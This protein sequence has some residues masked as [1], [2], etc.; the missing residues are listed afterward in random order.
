MGVGYNPKIVTDGL[1]MCLD[2]ANRKS[3]S[4]TGTIWRD[5]VGSNNGTLTNGPTYS[6]AGGGSIVFDGANDFVQC[7]GSITVTA[8]TFV[9]WIRRNGSQGTY[10]GILYS[11][12]DSTRFT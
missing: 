6:S 4:G 7:L 1:V 5:L 8:A 11:R 9:T 2:A 12:G 3:Y 10:D